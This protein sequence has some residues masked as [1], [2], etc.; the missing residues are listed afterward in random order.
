MQPPTRPES[1]GSQSTWWVAHRQPSYHWN[2]SLEPQLS[3]TRFPHGHAPPVPARPPLLVTEKPCRRSSPHS[4][5]VAKRATRTE[6]LKTTNLRL[7]STAWMRQ[8][9]QA[10]HALPG[11]LLQ[12]CTPVGLS[13]TT[14]NHLPLSKHTTYSL[15]WCLHADTVLST[16]QSIS[17]SPTC[18][19][20]STLS[21]QSC[22]HCLTMVRRLFVDAE[23]SSTA[24]QPTIT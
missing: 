18:Q 23:P 20:W 8:Q 3:F 7:R 16:L 17:I 6:K 5:M 19:P 22:L 24:T 11:Q 1:P 14:T 10:D 9:Q 4:W 15:Y 13:H 2:H 21:T 12:G